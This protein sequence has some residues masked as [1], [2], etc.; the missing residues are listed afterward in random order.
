MSAPRTLPTWSLYATTIIVWGTTFL[1]IKYQLGVTDPSVSVAF[2][3]GLASL[4]LFALCKLRGAKLGYDLRTHFSFALLGFLTFSLAYV[5]IYLA[6]RHLPSGMVAVMYALMVFWNA[7]A[8]RLIFGTPL[9]RKMMLAAAM[10]VGGVVC[11]FW[12]DLMAAG[13]MAS[14]FDTKASIAMV[15]VATLSSCVGNMVTTANARKEIAVLPSSA[16]SMAWGALFVAA[17]A[18]ATGVPWTFDTRPGYTLSLLYLA[19]FGSV[20]AFTAYFTLMG[21]VGPAKSA[22]VGAMNPIL[23][24][25]LSVVVEGYHVGPLQF[26]GMLLSFAGLM[27]SVRARA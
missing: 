18:W 27:L 14:S 13:G 2:R 23:S 16:W 4:V 21:R 5:L 22:Y 1:A 19:L 6:E 11:L 9:T 7:F 12:P 15:L 10:G 3:F 8:A 24:V 20:A 25:A 26:F 17:Y